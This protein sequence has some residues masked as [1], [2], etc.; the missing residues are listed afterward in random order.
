LAQYTSR[1]VQTVPR[2][3]VMLRTHRIWGILQTAD[4]DLKCSA[5]CLGAAKRNNEARSLSCYGEGVRFIR[6]TFDA[7][8]PRRLPTYPW[9]RQGRLGFVVI[10]VFGGAAAGRRRRRHGCDYP[11]VCGTV[12]PHADESCRAAQKDMA[13][14]FNL[15]CGADPGSS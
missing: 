11:M 4:L 2:V 5:G 9:R 1:L 13:V 6:L 8:R 10:L 3:D 12:S 15:Q 14:N 7:G